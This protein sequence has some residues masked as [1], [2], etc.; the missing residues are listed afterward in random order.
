[1]ARGTVGGRAIHVPLGTGTFTTVASIDGGRAA[2]YSASPARDFRSRAN[3]IQPVSELRPRLEADASR[4][5]DRLP[6][7]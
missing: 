5:L 6:E 7:V 4:V 1:M 2:S 3:L